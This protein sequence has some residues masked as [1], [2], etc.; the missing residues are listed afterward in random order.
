MVGYRF[1]KMGLAHP[2]SETILAKFIMRTLSDECLIKPRDKNVFRIFSGFVA[3]GRFSA[4]IG[5]RGT[6]LDVCSAG[7]LYTNLPFGL[8][9]QTRVPRISDSPC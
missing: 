4:L 8:R 7:E 2:A 5:F 1:A 6:V 9:R 3:D